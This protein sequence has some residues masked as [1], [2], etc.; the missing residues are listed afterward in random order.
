M[1]AKGASDSFT[2]CSAKHFYTYEAEV[3]EGPDEDAGFDRDLAVPRHQ[4]R[5]AEGG[6]GEHQR[7]QLLLKLAGLVTAIVSQLDC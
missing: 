4:G 1:I 3:R 2:W 5:H 6:H 7:V